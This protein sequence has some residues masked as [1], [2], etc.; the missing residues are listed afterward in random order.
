MSRRVSLPGASELF[1]TTQNPEGH[2][3]E[4]A[5]V[6]GAEQTVGERPESRR[7]SRRSRTSAGEASGRVRHDE[8]ITVYVSTDELMALEEARLALRRDHA[9]GVDRGRIVRAAIAMAVADLSEHGDASALIERLRP[10]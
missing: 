2:P 7:A 8:K 10:T 1:R 6:H 3:E 4:A 5:P 9:V